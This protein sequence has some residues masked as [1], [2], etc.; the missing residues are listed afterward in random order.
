MKSLPSITTGISDPETVN[1]F[2]AELKYPLANV[3]QYL[4]EYV[5]S[6]DKKIGEC[7]FYNAPAFFYIG[8]MKPFD[9]KEYKRY[10][11]GCNLFKKDTLRIIF[12][13][14]SSANDP[15]GILEGNYKDGRRIV[16]LKSISDVKS[17]EAELKK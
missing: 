7:I 17:K 15:T 9:P 12:L 6:V 11:V 4:R 8:K 5:L 2:M 10:I 13:R 16:S 1:K 3:V 14:G